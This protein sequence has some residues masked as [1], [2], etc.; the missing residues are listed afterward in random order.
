MYVCVCVFVGVFVTPVSVRL[1]RAQSQESA[2]STEQGCDD[3]R[4]Q[5]QTHSATSSSGAV[6]T[7][8]FSM[9]SSKSIQR[10]MM[11]LRAGRRQNNRI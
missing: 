11:G 7:R 10:R 2:G 9:K 1:C 8:S 5:P 6:A 4:D 3:L